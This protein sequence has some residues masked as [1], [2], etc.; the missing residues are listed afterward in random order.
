MGHPNPHAPAR[1]RGPRPHPAIQC[2][3]HDVW[4][5][6]IALTIQRKHAPLPPT[7][8]APRSFHMPCKRPV[9][10]PVPPHP[11]RRPA[12]L[13]AHCASNSVVPGLSQA[14]PCLGFTPHRTS[15]GLG[16]KCPFHL[17]TATPERH[18]KPMPI[19]TP[20]RLASPQRTPCPR[21]APP[22]LRERICDQSLGCEGVAKPTH[23]EGDPAH[24]VA[25][26]SLSHH[27]AKGTDSFSGSPHTSPPQ[28]EG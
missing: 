9:S 6:P 8:L 14:Q 16:S 28:H 22:C 15:L 10:R 11:P 1:A 4:P 21:P 12:D 5:A 13:H 19:H 26:C 3:N 18:R 25:P 17:P 20:C 27:T 23:K 7:D 2:T 24:P